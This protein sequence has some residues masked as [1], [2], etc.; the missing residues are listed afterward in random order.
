MKKHL[1]LLLTP[2]LILLGLSHYGVYSQ[3]SK[4]TAAY[5]SSRIVW[6][7]GKVVTKVADEER[8]VPVS[9]LTI[10]FQR[11]DCKECIIAARTNDNGEYLVMV[12]KGKYRVFV[13]DTDENNL[14]FDVVA[15]KQKRIIDAQNQNSGE[16]FDVEII[17]LRP[18][19]FPML[20]F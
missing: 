9:Y 20:E 4:K 14:S 11:V 3:T 13:F 6:I 1:V 8:F 16:R 5:V 7:K 15:A 19:V 10:Y 17:G 2:V 18:L 12:G